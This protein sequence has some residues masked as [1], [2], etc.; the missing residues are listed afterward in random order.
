MMSDVK[1]K[2]FR[3]GTLK[4]E[5][6]ENSREAAAA[7][8]HAAATKLFEL[9]QSDSIVGV[10]FATGASQLETLDAL[11]KIPGLPWSQVRGFHLDEY[12]GI[13]H[14]HPASFR[15]YL[16]EHLTTRVAIGEFNEIEGMACNRAEMLDEYIKRIR[17]ANPRLCLLGIGENGHLAFNDP[18]EARF[19]D[20][21]VMK[22]VKLDLLCRRQQVAEGWFNRLDEV[23]EEAITLTIPTLLGVSTLIGSVPGERKAKIVRR[24]LEGPINTDCPASVLRVH[25]DATIFLDLESASEL[26]GLPEFD[27]AE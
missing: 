22:V 17:A 1:I 23:P 14:N 15:R 24:T 11:T 19:D 6:H 10:V 25:P 3:V 5:V 21:R 18:A 26:I 9:S 27:R 12:L 20:P 7:A 8:A 13:P 2:R 4:V 16:R